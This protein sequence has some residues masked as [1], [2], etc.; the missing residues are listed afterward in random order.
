MTTDDRLL[1]HGKHA[2]TPEHAS[3]HYGASSPEP[4]YCAI[5]PRHAGAHYGAYASLL[6]GDH[7]LVRELLMTSDDL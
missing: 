5:L 2:S 7:V 4:S 3:A 6:L 1:T